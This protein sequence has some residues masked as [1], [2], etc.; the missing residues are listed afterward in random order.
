M[1]YIHYI[2]AKL[3][4]MYYASLRYRPNIPIVT[5]TRDLVGVIGSSAGR[6]ELPITFQHCI[7]PF[8]KSTS[9]I[10]IHCAISV[11]S[12]IFTGKQVMMLPLCP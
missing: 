5:F 11:H 6:T 9:D 10:A 1:E 12:C 3:Q 7:V 4:L 8:L 2:Y